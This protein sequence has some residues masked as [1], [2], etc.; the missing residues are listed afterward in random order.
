L[1]VR[2]FTCLTGGA[3]HAQQ[4]EPRAAVASKPDA[5]SV[6]VAEVDASTAAEIP[7]PPPVAAS[8]P[9]LEV[10]VID[11]LSQSRVRAVLQSVREETSRT[12]A[13][14]QPER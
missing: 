11:D 2:G 12:E 3:V 6:E 13:R 10:R 4:A 14:E 8:A 7:A 9:Q 1:L 5:K